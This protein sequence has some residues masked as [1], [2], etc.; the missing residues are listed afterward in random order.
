MKILII[1][2]YPT[3]MSVEKNTYNIQEVGLAKALVRRGHVCD[4]LFW[5]DR[6]EESVEIP[7]SND[8]VVHVFYRH[9]K[10]L[11]KNTVFTG[12]ADL[13]TQYDVLQPAEYNQMQA[14]LLAKNQPDKT[15]IYH[16]PYYSAFNKRYNLLCAVFDRFFLKNYIKQNSIFLVKSTL[17]KDFLEK[18]GIPASN[19]SVAGVGID[20]QMLSPGKA[21]CNEKVYLQ[22]K[23]QKEG[24]KILYVGRFEAR[25]DIPFLFH[26]FSCLLHLCPQ[27]RLYLIGS[28][29]KKY[30]QQSFD[31]ARRLGIYERTAWQERV[32]QRY[33]SNVYSLADFFLLPTEYEIFGMVLLEAM[34]YKSVVLTTKNGGSSMLIENE[35]NGFILEK[36]PIEWANCIKK[37]YENKPRMKEIQENAFAKIEKQFTWDRLAEGFFEQYQ[38]KAMEER[39]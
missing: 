10:T 36:D 28:G 25:R 16:G 4:I 23:E 21:I 1:R 32:E 37:T 31:Y 39:R 33:L 13:F 27:A 2:N 24:P 3:Y 29:T 5:T 19:I 12:C 30:L 26:T 15:V 11:L 38:V 17:A 7:V 8:G 34:Y 9:G 35:K 18:K 20:T 6:T 22:M 14:W